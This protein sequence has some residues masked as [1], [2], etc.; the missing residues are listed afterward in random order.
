MVSRHLTFLS[1][2]GLVRRE[3][4]GRN[5][6]FEADGPAIVAQLERV[7]ERFRALVPLCC[8]RGSSTTR[9]GER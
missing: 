9:G 6:F 7:L 2:A 8:P 4:V 5:A 3:K 1:E